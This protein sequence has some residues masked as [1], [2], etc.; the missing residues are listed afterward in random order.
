MGLDAAN[1]PDEPLAPVTSFSSPQPQTP[2]RAPDDAPFAIMSRRIVMLWLWARVER[3]GGRGYA[4]PCGMVGARCRGCGNQWQRNQNGRLT[5]P[6]SGMTCALPFITRIPVAVLRGTSSIRPWSRLAAPVDVRRASLDDGPAVRLEESVQSTA[7]G[8]G[9]DGVSYARL[10]T[11]FLRS[12]DTLIRDLLAPPLGIPS[13]P[14][15]M[16]RFAW[17]G[18]RSARGLAE[19]LFRGARARALFAGCAAHSILPLEKPLSAGVGLVFALSGHLVNW[20]L[21]RGS[22]SSRRRWPRSSGR[23]VAGS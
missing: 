8:L 19:G 21:A 11:P 4:R 17:Y 2:D 3:P 5:L 10:L 9:G 15:A 16:A 12:S 7:I 23:S 1:L 14:R 18:I 6:V 13:G 22:H 20:P